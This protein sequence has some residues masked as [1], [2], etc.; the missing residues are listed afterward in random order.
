MPIYENNN[1]LNASR[2]F[3]KTKVNIIP[4]DIQELEMLIEKKKNTLEFINL[5]YDEC[6]NDLDIS[7]Y[8]KGNDELIIYEKSEY[9][10]FDTGRHFIQTKDGKY[11]NWIYAV[12]INKA[13]NA[14]QDE[15]INFQLILDKR[16]LLLAKM[17]II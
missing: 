17:L 13:Y 8:L 14:L 2:Y 4:E 12:E 5:I 15:I 9:Y 3:N 10:V 7:N 6:Y 11:R 16:L 1:Q